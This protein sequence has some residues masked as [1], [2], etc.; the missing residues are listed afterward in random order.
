MTK[1]ITT[2]APADI[3]TTFRAQFAAKLSENAAGIDPHLFTVS[4]IN[5]LKRQQTEVIAALLGLE[6]AHDGGRARYSSAELPI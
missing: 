6:K 3:V 4:L 5:D 2:L 1:P